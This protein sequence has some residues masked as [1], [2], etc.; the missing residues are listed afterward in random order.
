M[1]E[2][3]RQKWQEGLS[4]FLEPGE[5]VEAATRGVRAKFWQMA[6][7]FGYLIVALLGRYRTYVVTDKNVYVFQA[8]AWSKYKVTK[9]VV[10]RPLDSAR[11]EFQKGYLTLDGDNEAFVG[12]V[13]PVKAQGVAVAE[14]ASRGSAPAA[15][16]AAA[17]NATV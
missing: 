12:L 2:S 17:S 7:I 9:L 4:E 16:N 5:R 15:A 10:K 13:G 3:T 6:L 1:K 11:V 8:S 14:A